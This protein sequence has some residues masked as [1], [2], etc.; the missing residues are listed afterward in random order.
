MKN[1]RIGVG[2]TAFSSRGWAVMVGLIVVGGVLASGMS[3]APAFALDPG[4][5]SAIVLDM[6]TLSSFEDANSDALSV[7]SDSTSDGQRDVTGT[8]A[9][10]VTPFAITIYEAV[11][12]PNSSTRLFDDV[13]NGVPAENDTASSDPGTLE[14]TVAVATTP[15]TM[16]VAWVATT[17]DNQYALDVDG[18]QAASG[19]SPNFTLTGLPDGTSFSL[20]LQSSS[21]ASS[22]GSSET[23]TP[24]STSDCTSPTGVR[25]TSLSSWDT[26][27]T[28]D[29]ATNLPIASGL[30]VSTQRNDS[31]TRAA[32]SHATSFAL[33]N[34]GTPSLSWSGTE[35]APVLQF[36]VD[37]DN[38][39][40]DDGFLREESAGS[41][42]YF[43]NND[44]NGQSH[45][46]PDAKSIADWQ[47]AY[48]DAVVSSVGYELGSDAIGAGV[49]TQLSAA[50]TFYTFGLPTS[51]PED[52][53][54][55]ATSM[56]LSVATP[57]AVSLLNEMSHAVRQAA[58]RRAATAAEP[59][60]RSD[61]HS[62]EF[63]YRTFIPYDTLND[64]PH[65]SDLAIADA[66]I[67]LWAAANDPSLLLPTKL[68]FLTFAGDNR[69]SQQPSDA[70]DFRT[71]M[72]VKVNWDNGSFS[73]NKLPGFTRL[74]NDET[75]EVVET[76]QANTDNLT[77]D[78]PV[79]NSNYFSVWMDHVANDPFCP[80][81]YVIGSITYAVHLQIYRSGLTVVRGLRSTMP[82][83]EGWVRWNNE[84][85]WSRVFDLKATE[86][87][88]LVAAGAA[89]AGNGVFGVPITPSY[90][91]GAIHAS[92]DISKD[93]WSGVGTN[94]QSTLAWSTSGD[95]FGWGR[96]DHGVLQPYA[97]T[98][99]AINDPE[100]VPGV[101]SGPT[102]WSEIVGHWNDFH[103]KYAD[104][105]D[106]N[107]TNI[108]KSGLAST[109]GQTFGA[110]DYL[111]QQS[112]GV[113]NLGRTDPGDYSP[114][115]VSDSLQFTDVAQAWEETFAVG[116]DG[117]IYAWG[118]GLDDYDPDSGTDNYL[119][120]Y[121]TPSAIPKSGV[122]FK[123]VVTTAGAALALDS[124]GHMWGLGSTFWAPS[125]T[126]SFDSAW[127]E[128]DAPNATFTS[129]ALQ[130]SGAAYALDS[131]GN[132]WSW[133]WSPLTLASGPGDDGSI[134]APT[135]VDT[136]KSF[137]RLDPDDNSNQ[138]GL[139]AT[140]GSL[141]SIQIYSGYPGEPVDL[142]TFELTAPDE[143]MTSVTGNY[144]IDDLGD[145]WE[146]VMTPG[147]DDSS[148]LAVDWTDRGRPPVSTVANPPQSC[149]YNS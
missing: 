44:S 7:D 96:S 24:S 30:M 22:G 107:A 35:A 26:S 32:A 75:G 87:A 81:A 145:L 36:A 21:T 88:C 115:K 140:D 53:Q 67:Q 8:E 104:A 127:T 10:G 141:Y 106:F 33:A 122:T 98:N 39:G 132:L 49:I 71:M 133:G 146:F 61:V 102:S 47:G 69:T 31:S 108:S 37:S 16:T 91:L 125:S 95:L 65:L 5:E 66:C 147:A 103:Y 113:N 64:S 101:D 110:Y 29:N 124:D 148:S 52:D 94:D 57:A 99:C 25:S 6:T 56:Q 143:P 93:S 54:N 42:S 142:S 138:I 72:D 90:C 134:D 112:Y 14:P 17:A 100:L 116:S 74:V 89:E 60:S 144:G 126:N 41:T 18:T 131:D 149:V 2:M 48:P 97:D 80:S 9:D 27:D 130:Q 1:Q 77:F 135:L 85:Q 120:N 79:Q 129:I 63:N 119:F 45:S 73:H 51:S 128:I 12:D 68:P 123:K 83:H 4:Q 136:S 92:S 70:T 50:C 84:T 121:A 11:A 114:G 13:N 43:L 28:T 117:Q 118:Q 40:S 139:V 105:G 19:S 34:I 82:E 109:W 86:L 46:Q 76:K 3:G 111:T 38:D 55:N 15:T 58:A 23:S 62:T 137:S 78:D 59:L 20:A